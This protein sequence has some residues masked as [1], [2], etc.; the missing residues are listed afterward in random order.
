[1]RQLL[2]AFLLVLSNQ[3]FAVKT[4]IEKING[5]E[6]HLV[7]VERGDNLGVGF[8]T[9]FGSMNDQGRMM[10]RAHFLEHFLHNGSVAFPGYHTFQQ[11]TDSIGVDTNAFTAADKTYYFAVGKQQHAAIMLPVHLAMLGGLEWAAPTFKKQIEAV[12]D[13]IVKQGLPG[14]SDALH[15][16]PSVALL[17][18]GHPWQAVPMLGD[19]VNL[20]AMTI[21]D[22]KDLYYRAYGPDM[23]KVV[24]AGN[25]SKPENLQQ[26]REI[27]AQHLK[28]F[29]VKKDPQ[30]FTPRGP[31]HKGNALPSLA[32]AAGKRLL[33]QSDTMMAGKIVMET[34]LRKSNASGAALG[35]MVAALGL[36]VPG[37]FLYKLT[38]ELGWVTGAG[39]W[40]NQFENRTFLNFYYEMTAEGLKHE[41][42]IEAMMFAA[43]ADMHWNG[44]PE[45]TFGFLKK[46][47]AKSTQRQTYDVKSLIEMYPGIL[48]D[49]GDLDQQLKDLE[50]VTP[51]DVRGMASRFTAD[52]AMYSLIQPSREGMSTDQRFKRD[53]KIED[54]RERVAANV[55]AHPGDKPPK[56]T[57]AVHLKR[58][59][60]GEIKPYEQ[61]NF[62]TQTRAVP[63]LPVR[64]TLDF[65]KDLPDVGVMT[66]LRLNPAKPQDLAALDLVREAFEERY[67]G[68]LTTIE[69]KYFVRLHIE[70]KINDWQFSAKGDD[71]YAPKALTWL[72]EKLTAFEP[73]AEE[74]ERAKQTLATSI[75]SELLNDF[76]AKLVMDSIRADIDPLRLT[77][78]DT[79]AAL[80]NTDV[81]ALTGQ[82][83][84]AL[85]HNSQK[86]LV[87]AGDV[88]D[89]DGFA[90][91]NAVAQLS[92]KFLTEESAA[93][94][95]ARGRFEPRT[96][97][98]QFPAGRS[99]QGQ[100]VARVYKGPA[101]LDVKEGT[102][103]RAL[104]SLLNT[105]I[106]ILNREER[107]LGYVHQAASG[108]VDR[109]N[110]F[111][112]LYGQT[113]GPGNLEKTIAGWEEVLRA[114]ADGALDKDIERAIQDVVSQLTKAKT[115][116][117]KLIESYDL[118][119]T[120]H[121]DARFDRK[122][123]EAAQK[124]TVADVRAIAKKYVLGEAI[125]YRQLTLSG[126]ESLL[127]N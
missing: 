56:Q 65:R 80:L 35:M 98:R 114:L 46:G 91:H 76:S 117:A 57:F 55:K 45:E 66:T 37:S 24:A 121:F 47:L 49:D 116:A 110:M 95:S 23:V 78:W 99:D 6:V 126:C 122:L 92:P 30:G 103:F 36:K 27:L 93:K 62:F 87:I 79:R 73:T 17:P 63:G 51:A 107:G 4:I 3:A 13:E 2:V 90:L 44:V 101:A 70:R 123:A 100:A 61:P 8:F 1:M 111:L 102:A 64:L 97:I 125:Q 38:T 69:M 115:S 19:G 14:E 22:M 85:V 50:E 86:E 120:L 5:F 41:K 84:R 7:D 29:D 9:P 20:P 67:S 18:A 31:S 119:Q 81:S 39:F 10:G 77:P 52:T 25:F 83:W 15:M 74:L 105:K 48:S 40:S 89:I 53:F 75:Q 113:E 68:E 58:L 11:T 59:D 94:L 60:L 82:K 28:P 42:E 108:P 88:A 43:L 127:S 54:N 16:M 34:E 72:I 118:Y 21:D 106:Y 26:V 32:G 109:V 104:A 124:L 71:R 96:L 33:L 112:L 12:I